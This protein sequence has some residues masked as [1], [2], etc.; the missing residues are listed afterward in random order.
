LTLTFPD[1]FTQSEVEQLDIALKEAQAHEATVGSRDF[2]GGSDGGASI[3]T[4]LLRQ[5]PGAGSLIQEAEALQQASQLQEREVSTQSSFSYQ[6]RRTDSFQAPPGSVGG[7]P[8]PGIPGMNIDPKK[9]GAQIYPILEFRDKV[10]KLLAAT[11]EK[12]PGLEALVQ[13]ISE[14]VTLFVLS[15]LAPFIRPIITQV[16]KQLKAGS[17]TVIDASGKHQYEPWTDPHCTDPTHSMLSK[18]H[19]SNVLNPPAGQV[20]AAILQYAAPRIIY[21]WENPSI[22][23][24][25]VITD[26]LRVFHHP[27]LRDQ[28]CQ[29]HQQMYSVVEK[30]AQSQRGKIDLNDILSSES[31]KAGRNAPEDDHNH[32][33]FSYYGKVFGINP[34]QKELDLQHGSAGA[35]LGQQFPGTET[36][37][38]N[39]AGRTPEPQGGGYGA[40]PAPGYGYGN[41]G[42]PGSGY[43]HGSGYGQEAQAPAGAYGSGRWGESAGGG[44]PPPVKGYGSGAWGEG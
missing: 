22:P 38:D 13:K 39:R 25:E 20:A 8:G 16:S 10:V 3:M 31:V 42:Y 11:L 9:V 41:S 4:G 37:Y 21:A 26:I 18:D 27:A 7:P 33:D 6:E 44:D 19:F 1:H 28:R 5:I 43:G 29:L 14:T 36:A 30:W 17:T 23:T 32:A 34:G 2:L 15:L 12:I 24:E 40:P 35:T